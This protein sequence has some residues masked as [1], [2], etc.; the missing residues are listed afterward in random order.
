MKLGNG[1]TSDWWF[2]LPVNEPYSLH[3]GCG[4]SP[5]SWTVSATTLLVNGPHNSFDCHDVA[6]APGFRK[7]VS[8]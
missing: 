5:A 2:T 8:R 7:C 4:G 3:V 1:S 6:G